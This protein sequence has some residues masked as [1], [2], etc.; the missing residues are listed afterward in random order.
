[1]KKNLILLLSLMYAS[2]SF[3]IDD[4]QIVSLFEGTEAAETDIKT[5]ENKGGIFSFLNFKKNKSDSTSLNVA[6]KK[7]LSTEEQA[8]KL[9]EAGNVDAQ[10]FLGY[11]YLYGENNFSTNYEKA[12]EYYAKAA[13]QNN[14][15]ALNNLG[16][17]YYSGVGVDRN[18]AKAAVLFEKSA[19]LG[20]AEAAVNLG[21][22]LISGNGR[23]KNPQ[24]AMQ[25]FENASKIGSAIAD[26]MVG[27]AHYRGIY[28][29]KDLSKAAQ[30]IKKAASAGFD[31][32]QY[33]LAQ[34][35]IN[36]QGVPQ[37]YGTAVKNLKKAVAQGSVEAMSDLGNMLAQGKKYAK[38]L[39]FAHMM[40]NIAAVYGAHGAAE[41][42]NEIEAKLKIDELLQAQ[43]EAER[44]VAKPSELSKYIRQTFGTNVRQYIDV[45]K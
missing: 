4:S 38:D 34:M 15:I 41:K 16:S 24:L 12:Y 27:Y 35:Y 31:E 19:K 28:R 6:D 22:I 26:F 45:E 30:L 13:L 5:E 8:I 23:E 21:F 36:G 20:N 40:Y 39:Y 17:L 9:A 18:S 11:S 14:P 44:Y 1:M 3:A 2:P 29:D 37:N 32:A 25:Y 7:R 33:V 42:R 43:A 10:L